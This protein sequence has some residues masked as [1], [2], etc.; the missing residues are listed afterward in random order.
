MLILILPEGATMYL[1]SF[2]RLII[3]GL[4][5]TAWMSLVLYMGPFVGLPQIDIGEILGSTWSL[6]P[7]F[8][9]DADWW[10]AIVIHFFLGGIAFPLFYRSFLVDKA[11]LYGI[12]AGLILGFGL[13]GAAMTFAFP[14]FGLGF[15][16]RHTA[17]PFLINLTY[18]I[19]HL[20]YGA[21][22]GGIAIPDRIEKQFE[23]SI[24][25]DTRRAA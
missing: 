20:V 4:I 11:S 3:A 7:V 5:A 10:G 14:V 9:G 17:S 12:P 21:V 15:F 23:S 2:S 25:I 8:I 6:D 19:A 22:L 1:V 13:Y 24:P 16:A 18:M